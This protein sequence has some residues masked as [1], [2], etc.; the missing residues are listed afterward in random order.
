MFSISSTLFYMP[1]SKSIGV[2]IDT[3][4]AEEVYYE[5]PAS[6]VWVSTFSG[7]AWKLQS[8][9]VYSNTITLNNGVA[10]LEIVWASNC[11]GMQALNLTNLP[12]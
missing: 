9:T 7:S 8:A 1:T 6:N 11:F 10:K 5:E 4:G 3:A 2:N 12:Q